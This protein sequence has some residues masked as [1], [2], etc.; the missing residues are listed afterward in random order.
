MPNVQN[1]VLLTQDGGKFVIDTVEN[2]LCDP[3]QKAFQII[4]SYT[5]IIAFPRALFPM[6]SSC[7]ITFLDFFA[8]VS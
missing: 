3:T 7:D 6:L 2:L 8:A 1:S 5:T 4:Q